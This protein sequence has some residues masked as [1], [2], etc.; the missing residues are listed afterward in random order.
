MTRQRMPSNPYPARLIRSIAEEIAEEF[1][2]SNVTSVLTFFPAVT[3]MRNSTSITLSV[4]SA[5]RA[6]VSACLTCV[7]I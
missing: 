3:A 6:S 4:H 7:R 1:A 5:S 2:F